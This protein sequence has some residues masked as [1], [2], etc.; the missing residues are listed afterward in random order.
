MKRSVTIRLIEWQKKPQRKPL[1]LMGARQVGKTHSLLD[2]GEQE[3]EACHHFDFEEDHSLTKIFENSLSPARLIESLSVRKGIK[4][5][6]EAD[7][8]IFDEI[9]KVPR[10]ITSL[11]YIAEQCPHWFV[12]ASGSLLGVGL[13]QVS[14]PVG[15]VERV[16]MRPMTFFEFLDAANV[17]VLNEALQNFKINELQSE[18]IHEEAW[19]YLKFYMITGGLPEVVKTFIDNIKDLPEVFQKVRQLQ[20]NL[21]Q[22]YKDDIAKHSGKLKSIKIQSVLE[23]IP[24]QLA[25]ESHSVKKFIVKDVLRNN[26]KHAEL[27][28]PIQ[29]LINAGLI[30]KVP[31]CEKAKLPLKAYT[32]NNRFIIYL[33]D[34]GILGAMM[35]LSPQSIIEYDYGTYKGYFAENFILQELVG[36]EENHL[37]NWQ[38]N[39]SQI[40]FLTESSGALIPIEVKAGVSTKAK[41]LSVFQAKYNPQLALLFC[42]KHYQPSN[43]SRHTFPLYMAAQLHT[44]I[45]ALSS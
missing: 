13:N 44:I 7:L 5:N 15:K 8:I 24:L 10:A 2:F 25:R 35:N 38:E 21:L 9:Q 36:L 45:N 18:I 41:S 40:E 29:W 11:K 30:H 42:G 37:Y 1:L 20:N 26:S 31:I 14:F 33:F 39:T 34:I 17:P 28:A 22:D 12:I 19:R 6:P 27:E 16:H 32:Q 43:S 4:I 23:S 3:F